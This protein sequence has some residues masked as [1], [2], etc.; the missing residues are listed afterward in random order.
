MINMAALEQALAG[1]EELGRSELEFLAGDTKVV[2]RMLSPAEEMEVQRYA[3]EATAKVGDKAPSDE[4]E[5]AMMEFMDRFKLT[6]LAY[7]IT[8]IGSMDLSE[9]QTV[10][11][12]EQTDSGKDI[13][14][15]K[16][17][18][19]RNLLKRWTRPILLSCFAKYGELAGRV[20]RSAETKIKWEPTDL[21]AEIERL[22]RRLSEMLKLQQEAAA[23]S[24][25]NRTSKQVQAMTALDEQQRRTGQNI[26]DSPPGR[27]SHPD[28]YASDED[29]DEDDPDSDSLV[30]DEKPDDE[31][32]VV[33]TSAPSR[34]T[35]QAPVSAPGPHPAGGGRRSSVPA[36]ASAPAPPRQPVQSEDAAPQT[37]H[38]LQT[39]YENIMD[40]MTDLSDENALAAENARLLEVRRR[41][42]MA[43]EAAAE[44]AAAVRAD[45]LGQSHEA[46]RQAEGGP[47]RTRRRVPPHRAAAN[48]SD[49]VLDAGAAS[50]RAARPRSG[51]VHVGEIKG[52]EVFALEPQTISPR[53]AIPRA[54]GPLQVN[55]DSPQQGATNPRFRKG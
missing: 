42:V 4:K 18:A 23:P 24:E 39:G 17:E 19:V 15:P 13:H 22:Q 11:T 55:K 20:E 27:L 16:H 37:A 41:Q 46:R 30:P 51:A 2:L 32:P 38:S 29:E 28:M 45:A 1:I 33:V 52:R 43:E 5:L 48:T 14:I 31:P 10:A 40:S 25:T 6:V 44:R 35:R 50:E 8:Q 9:V 12:G 49:A 26:T 36:A 47:V 54:P 21:S 53:T 3:R 7:S 34:M